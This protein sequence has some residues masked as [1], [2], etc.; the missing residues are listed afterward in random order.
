M[1]DQE[2][3]DLRC[4]NDNA[5]YGPAPA[6]PGGRG[7]T[8]GP[9]GKM[10][11][12][13]GDDFHSTFTPLVKRSI[14]SQL[15]V[16]YNDVQENHDESCGFNAHTFGYNVYHL[17]KFRLKELSEKSGGSLEIVGEIGGL[18]RLQNGKFKIGVYK[19]G[20]SSQTNIWESFPST[21]NGANS[22]NHEFQLGFSEPEFELAM[23]DDVSKR[24]YVIIA[25]MGNATDGLAAV[26]LCIPMEASREGK[27]TRWGYAEQ[28]YCAD[29]G[30]GTMPAAPDRPPPSEE[31]ELP[32]LTIPLAEEPEGEV[33]VTPRGND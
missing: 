21:E 23:L 28:I 26:Y 18:F 17:A 4:N 19:V 3:Q 11:P 27:I 15:L 14:V 32:L 2:P 24:D 20:S 5:T 30:L 1:S 33:K 9:F 10:N 8:P 6:S 12:D 16:A 25:H 31:P 29:D 22:G 13:P 7:P